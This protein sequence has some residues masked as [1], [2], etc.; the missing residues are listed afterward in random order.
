[1][2]LLE[3]TAKLEYEIKALAG[4]RVKIQPKTSES[5]KTITKALTEKHKAFHKYKPKEE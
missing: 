5:Y 3:K 1:M 4:N 2:Q